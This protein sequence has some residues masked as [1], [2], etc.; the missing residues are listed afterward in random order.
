MVGS[1]LTRYKH[2][3]DQELE[4]LI[5]KS[6]PFFPTLYEG[7]RYALLAPGKRIR[8]I[9]T[10]LTAE[11]LKEES[12]QKALRP[13]CALEMIHTYSLIH[14][15]LP[16]MDDDDFRRGNPTLHRVYNEGH[17]VLVG[18]YLLTHAFE[19]ISSAPELSSDQKIALIQTLSKAAGGEGMIGGQVMDLESS[20]EIEQMHTFKTAAL[21][22]CAVE[23]GGIVANV[24][25]SL[26]QKLRL[27]GNQFGQL[28]QLLDDIH[29]HDHPLGE[30]KAKEAA[31]TLHQQM[32][33]TLN[34]LP[35]NT[36]SLHQLIHAIL[37]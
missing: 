9:L 34:I 5:P 36:G 3:I 19:V 30:E 18:D 16:C 4:Q 25:D 12:T 15:D 11:M 35:G 6:S 22:R 21:F 37:C 13:A 28:F 10:L 31:E 26:M 29:D 2:C 33:K 7:G 20:H 32:L 8:P 1:L 24:S 23:F 14:D 17:A 27:F